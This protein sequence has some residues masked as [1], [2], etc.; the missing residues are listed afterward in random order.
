[1]EMPAAQPKR[2]RHLER[3]GPCISPEA[4]HR[5]CRH[6]LEPASSRSC[7][8][9]LASAQ[10]RAPEYRSTTRPHGTSNRSAAWADRVHPVP[11]HDL[12]AR[13]LPIGGSLSTVA[14]AMSN[15]SRAGEDQPCARK[16]RPPRARIDHAHTPA[17]PWRSRRQR[18]PLRRTWCSSNAGVRGHGSFHAR[19]SR[20]VRCVRLGAAPG[21]HGR[22]CP[23]SSLRWRSAGGACAGCGWRR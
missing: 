9:A 6:P 13:E 12:Y 2:D 14:V 20:R 15:S 17:S 5:P 10:M 4:G 3:P 7:A 23:V 21:P 11:R 16:G 22:R 18:T 8:R 1:M 19:L